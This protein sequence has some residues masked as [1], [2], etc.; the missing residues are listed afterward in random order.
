[1]KNSL[2]S[3]ILDWLYPLR[4]GICAERLQQ[5]ERL[6]CQSCQEGGIFILEDTCQKCGRAVEKDEIYCYDCSHNS[7]HY[8]KGYAL[9][10]YSE[11]QEAILAMKYKREK[12]RLKV[13]ADLMAWLYEEVKREWQIDAIAYVPQHFLSLGEKGY[14]P[15]KVLAKSLAKAW[16]LPLTDSLACHPKKKHQKQL[17]KEDRKKNLKNIFYCKEKVKY[18]RILLI[19]DI[20]TTG[21]TIDACSLCLKQN[22][23]EEIYFL[24]IANGGFSQ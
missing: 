11:V 21:S 1:M 16:G 24:T 15:T 10:S 3:E 8:E 17:E 7:H 5:E 22:G 6:I 18:C 19:D 14:H 20:Y 12:W 9:F 13:M 23:A 2:L 4:C